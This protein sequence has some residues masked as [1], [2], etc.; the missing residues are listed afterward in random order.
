[1]KIVIAPDSYKESLSAAEVAL[2]TIDLRNQQA[3]L[4]IAQANLESFRNIEPINP[5]QCFANNIRLDMGSPERLRAMIH[6]L[7]HR[8]CAPGAPI[9]L[10]RIVAREFAL[11]A[12]VNLP[13][14]MEALQDGEWV[15]VDG[16]RGV[17]RR[18]GEG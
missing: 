14:I 9:P 8:F 16:G 6:A 13:G 11:P 2:A 4:S 3:R 7:L 10:T 12:V 1:M 5:F 17:V 18:V 15:E